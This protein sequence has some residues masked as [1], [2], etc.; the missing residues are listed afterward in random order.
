MTPELLALLAAAAPA[1]TAAADEAAAT[2]ANPNALSLPLYAAVMLGLA[3]VC[4]GMVLCLYRL[5]RGP[6][7]ADRVLASDVFAFH[8][9]ALVILLSVYLRNLT[10]FDAALGVAIVGFASTVGFAQYIGARQKAAAA[11][12]AD[13]PTQEPPR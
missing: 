9:V 8:V 1:T 12:A 10:F 13:I 4:A 5:W 3:S 7:L 11:A 6:G 2:Y